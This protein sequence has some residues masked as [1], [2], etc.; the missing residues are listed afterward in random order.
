[1]TA[2]EDDT[3]A[4]EREVIATIQQRLAA[5]AEDARR[6]WWTSYLKGEA[7]FRGTAMADVRRELAGVWRE[8][9]VNRPTVSVKRVALALLRERLTEDKLAGVL[10]LAE[11]LGGELGPQDLPQLAGPLADG[12][13]ADWNACDWYAVKVLGSQ[14]ARHGKPF[15]EPLACWAATDG[16]LWQRRAPAAAFASLAA[17][18]APFDGFATLCVRVCEALCIDDERFAQTAVGWLLRELSAQHPALV[19]AFVETHADRLSREARRMANA[20]LEGRGR[21]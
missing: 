18:P 3:R 17:K 5:C 8:H 12:S 2:D 11:H 14:V 10:L 1:M 6:E 13:I 20:K 7:A 4:G 15:A 19:V 16:P 9:L 21:R